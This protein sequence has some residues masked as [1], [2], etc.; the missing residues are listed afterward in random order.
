MWP[1]VIEPRI[2]PDFGVKLAQPVPDVWPQRVIVGRLHRPAHQPK[3]VKM[4]RDAG[5]AKCTCASALP[6]PGPGTT[7][8]TPVR[9]ELIAPRTRERDAKYVTADSLGYLSRQECTKPPRR[10]RAASATLASPESTWCS[11]RAAGDGRAP[12]GEHG[13]ARGK[14]RA[15]REPHIWPIRPRPPHS[16]SGLRLT[17]SRPA[18]SA[19][20]PTRRFPRAKSRGSGMSVMSLWEGRLRRSS[21][22]SSRP[23][24]RRAPA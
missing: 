13:A 22:C 10:S 6:R 16:G 14:P 9:S 1:H 11:W 8:D 24:P 4:I 3:I 19:R 15:R 2:D 5:G 20:P 12:G 7:A 21:T 18:A 23:G 17:R